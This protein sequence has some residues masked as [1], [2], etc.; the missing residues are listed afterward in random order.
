MSQIQNY[1][2][3]SSIYHQEDILIYYFNPYEASG[4]ID[5]K[6]PLQNISTMWFYVCLVF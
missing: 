5:Y 4:E 2:E 3:D 1:I 6:S